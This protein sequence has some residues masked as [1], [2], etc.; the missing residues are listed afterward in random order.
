M[1]ITLRVVGIF[2]KFPID[3]TG[4][5]NPNGYASVQDV[6]DAAI[7]QASSGAV[8]NVALFS[9]SSDGGSV[10]ALRAIYNESFQGPISG[11]TYAPGDYY[12]S[13]S[14]GAAPAKT[15][16]QYYVLDGNGTQLSSGF[17]PYNSGIPIVPDGGSLIWR[18]VSI[19]NGPN[20][21][22]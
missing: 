11:N 7:T 10:T 16:W 18:L 22:P 2:F 3:L 21:A 14:L 19:L 13:E 20:P 15:V 1:A 12:L 9:Y 4:R 8:N 5:L 17:S 6:L